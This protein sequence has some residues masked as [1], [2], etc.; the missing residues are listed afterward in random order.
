MTDKP[1]DVSRRYVRVAEVRT[2]G[3][4]EFEFSVGEPEM[5]V[6]LVMPKDAF[7][8]FCANNHVIFL[9]SKP[10]PKEKDS[11]NAEWQWNLHDATHQRFR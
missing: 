1:F 6:E 5:M 8:T 9:E 4:V 3:F 11:A 2:D 7:D 10:R